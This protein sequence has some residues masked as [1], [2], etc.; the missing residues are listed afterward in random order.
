MDI[1]E[2]KQSCTEYPVFFSCNYTYKTLLQNRSDSN[3]LPELRDQFTQSWKL[4]SETGA[5]ILMKFEYF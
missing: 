2:A 5:Q 3:P 1:L 4:G